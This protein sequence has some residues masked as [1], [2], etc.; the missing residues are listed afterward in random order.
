MTS[1]CIKL[2]A[3]DKKKT[4]DKK[5]VFDMTAKSDYDLVTIDFKHLLSDASNTLK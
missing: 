3:R 2:T 5:V 4:K 1:A